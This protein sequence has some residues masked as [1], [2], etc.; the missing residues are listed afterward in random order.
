MP[1]VRSLTPEEFKK[2]LYRRFEG[3]KKFR[4]LLESIW[5][6]NANI[7][8]NDKGALR[9]Q[10]NLT[11]DNVI[12]LESGEVDTG[13][14]EIGLNLTFK[15]L[16]FFHSQ[17]AANPPSVVARPTSSDPSDQR[18]ADAAD[19]MCRHAM[20]N[21]NY[22]EKVDQMSL[23]M[24]MFGTGY[25][26]QVWDPD[27]GDT[28]DFTEETGE[29]T[30]EGDIC[31][32]SPAITDLWLD[33]DVAT[34]D[35]AKYTIERHKMPLEEAIFK[36]PEFEKELGGISEKMEDSLKQSLFTSK[37]DEVEPMV[38][39]YEYYER[40]MPVNGMAG[41][42]CYFLEDYT[43]LGPLKRNPHY[44]RGL[45]YHIFTYIDVPDMIYGKSVVEYVST[46]QDMLNRLNSSILDNIQAHGV[47][48]F[49]CPD[50]ADIEDEAVSNSAWDWIKYSGP[51]PPHFAPAPQLMPDIW[52]FKESMELYI[53]DAF[54]INDSML[55]IQRREQSAVS[56]QTSIESGT[57]I[58]RRLWKKYNM[59]IES[60]YR[61][62]LGLVK[63][64]WDTPRVVLVMG[65]NKAFEAAELK[66]ADISGGF[67]LDVDYGVSLPIDPN[68]RREAIMLLTPLFKEAGMS[69]KSILQKMK[70][71]DLEGIQ[72]ILELSRDRQREEFDEMI[73]N[74]REGTPIYIEPKEIQ[75]H[76]G[77]LDYSY[78][79]V[80]TGEFKYLEEP[81]QE[82]IYRQI[83][84]REAMLQAQ[85]QPTP[86]SD[87]SVTAA[88]MPGVEG[89]IAPEVGTQV[90]LEQLGI[91]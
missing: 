82:L 23:N 65:K 51:N 18:K 4:A 7:V 70:L 83:R 16:R 54:G 19:R 28:Y 32:Y 81:L 29:I 21:G 46:P 72:D 22:Q 76:Q 73:A 79:F 10:F 24:L 27:L 63:E 89:A 20:K 58:H 31:A 6:T 75:E 33:P 71:N 86:A 48:R 50:N 69:A 14:S 57:M 45:P 12:E 34:W 52:K 59:A 88:G 26:K 42:H 1:K 85:M 56:Q 64:N 13:A 11:F 2:I 38:D 62:Y 8:M 30:M 55:G 61:D 36:W 9:D 74:Y 80:E 66:G 68:M 47:I 60:I 3:A 67:D 90:D 53:Q 87:A 43:L 37:S 25:L 77:R 40:G 78:E 5:K 39:I 49:M 17:L 84:D 35:K 44:Q 15:H 91:T 41:R